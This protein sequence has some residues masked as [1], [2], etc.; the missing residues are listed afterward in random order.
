MGRVVTHLLVLIVPSVL[1]RIVWSLFKGSYMEN[2]TSVGMT[3]D[4]KVFS[5]SLHPHTSLNS[6]HFLKMKRRGV[7]PVYSE[8]II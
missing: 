7:H 6:F 8:E 3:I 2:V 4:E 1:L 5:L